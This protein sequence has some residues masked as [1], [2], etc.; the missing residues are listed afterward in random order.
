MRI[1]SHRR[2]RY[3]RCGANHVGKERIRRLWSIWSKWGRAS[4]IGP[5]GEL[6]ADFTDLGISR[7]PR[8]HFTSKCPESRNP[9]DTANCSSNILQHPGLN[10]P[11]AD[12]NIN[13]SLDS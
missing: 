10:L 4:E 2:L 3:K 13:S 9:I 11:V 7:P 6:G 8:L 12:L 5:Q 1:L